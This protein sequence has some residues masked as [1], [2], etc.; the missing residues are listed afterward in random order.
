M[1]TKLIAGLC[2]LLSGVGVARAAEVVDITAQPLPSAE[3]QPQA[4]QPATP[5][6]TACAVV[7]PGIGRLN[8]M[9]TK[10]KAETAAS[11]GTRRVC[12]KRFTRSSATYQNGAAIA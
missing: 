7:P 8:I 5:M 2:F 4:V 1:T 12:N 6:P 3:E 9:T 11:N 10:Q